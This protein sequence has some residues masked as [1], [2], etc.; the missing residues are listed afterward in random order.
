MCMRKIVLTVAL[1]KAELNDAE[2]VAMLLTF[3]APKLPLSFSQS[4]L[5]TFP[6]L[7]SCTLPVEKMD[8]FS[9]K[10]K[11]LSPNIKDKDQYKTLHLFPGP[12]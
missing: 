7:K 11:V 10:T 6:A 1:Y 4:L 3:F 9:K 8:S 2:V 5:E 12:V